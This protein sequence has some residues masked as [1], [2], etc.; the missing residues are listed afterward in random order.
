MLY[1][2]DFKDFSILIIIIILINN[3]VFLLHKWMRKLQ[4]S[5]TIT[6]SMMMA[7]SWDRNTLEI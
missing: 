5:K 3:V 4:M 2:T 6:S 1:L 7:N